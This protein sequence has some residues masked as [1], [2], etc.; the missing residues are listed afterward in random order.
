[1]ELTDLSVA[2][3]MKRAKERRVLIP[4]FNIA[5][6]AMMKPVVETIVGLDSFGLVEAAVPD[7]TKFGAGS[8]SAVYEEFKKY[9][10]R[11]HVRLHQDHVPVV[12]EESR[13]VD[14]KPFIEESLR[15]G[16]DSVMID[17][18][19]LDFAENIEVTKE[20][21]SMARAKNVA[22]EAELGAVL[23]HEKG[24]LPPYEEL[25]ATGKGF[26]D[27]E[28]A[29]TFVKETGVDWLSVAIGNVHGAISGT[30]KD[31][32]KISARLNISHLKKIEEVTGVPLVLH[33]GSGIPREYVLEG[34][35][36]GIC[37]I[38]IGTEIR[39]AYEKGM[40]EN[41]NEESA[42]GKVAEKMKNLIKDYFNI[43]NS[44]KALNKGE[45]I[46]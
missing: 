42:R 17:A 20:V 1:M 10:N 44:A 18:S 27:V 43:E 37:K 31:Q 15:L 23:G 30:A 28:Q 3:I 39:Q 5:Y 24:P 21:V 13:K 36:N 41:N 45:K 4:A 33:G 8:F 11:N 40:K 46:G 22:V 12:D 19:R 6:L 26:T 14:W 32:K 16:Y 35:K 7:I 2:E 9:E 38:N 29:K 25:F 34:I